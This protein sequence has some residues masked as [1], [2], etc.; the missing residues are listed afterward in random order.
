MNNI[1]VRRDAA[2]NQKR[3]DKLRKEND[4]SVVC[5]SFDLK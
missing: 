3:K 5:A 1:S 4:K 2:N